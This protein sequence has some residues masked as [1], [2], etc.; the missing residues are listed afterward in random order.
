M[1]RP[2]S[3]VPSRWPGAPTGASRKRIDPAVGSYG[4]SHGART[5]EST[6]STSTPAASSVVRSRVSRHRTVRQ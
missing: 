6:M 4:A 2:C 3:S 5:A 1:S